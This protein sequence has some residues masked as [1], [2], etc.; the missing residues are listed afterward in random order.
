MTT[1]DQIP[2]TR[3][4]GWGFY[5]TMKGRADEAWSLAMTTASKATGSP[6]EAVRLFLDSSFRRHFSDEVLNALHAGQLLAAAIDATA[7]VWMQHKTNSWLIEIYDIP[8]NLPHLTV[9]VAANEIADDL[10]A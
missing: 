5:G 10:S 8:R 2:A 7:T 6:L 4:E 1:A 9:S 3:T